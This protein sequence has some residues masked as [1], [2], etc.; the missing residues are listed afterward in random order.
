MFMCFAPSTSKGDVPKNSNKADFIVRLLD[1][2]SRPG[3]AISRALGK[4]AMVEDRVQTESRATERALNKVGL[5]AAA[6]GANATRGA[7]GLNKVSAAM[8]A[9]RRAA[10]VSDAGGRQR[11]RGRFV[12]PRGVERRNIRNA[13]VAGAPVA[14]AA[15]GIAGQVGGFR[16]AIQAVRRWNDATGEA[17]RKQLALKRAFEDTHFGRL[18]GGFKTGGKAVARLSLSLAK[19]AAQAVATAGALFGVGAAALAFKTVQAGAF[20]ERSR[21]ALALL[22]GSADEGNRAFELARNTAKDLGLDVQDVV[23]QF[24]KLRAAQFTIGETENLVKLG[25]DLQAIGASAEQVDRAILAITQVKAKGRLQSEELLQLSE[26]GVSMA[27]VF[28]E[29]EK[30]TGKSTSGVRKLL[31]AGKVSGDQGVLAIQNAILH[32]VGIERAG[33]AGRQFADETLTG[34]VNRLKTLPGRLLLDLG[35]LIDTKQ[36]RKIVNQL[37]GALRNID[38]KTLTRGINAVIKAF[39]RAI[40]F[41]ISFAEGFGSKIPDIVT[42]MEDFGRAVDPTQTRD[43]GR[44]LGE[45][46][47]IA[48]EKGLRLTEKIL[49]LVDAL[50]D[51]AKEAGRLHRLLF[52]DASSRPPPLPTEM[53]AI[54]QGLPAAGAMGGDIAGASMLFTDPERFFSTIFSTPTPTPRPQQP[55]ARTVTVAPS[56]QVNVT[57]GQDAQRTAE[58]VREGARK[59]LED[60]ADGPMREAF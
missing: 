60:F 31:Q 55:Q 14:A 41:G 4:I 47:G 22:T 34:M 40:D 32:K 8:L 49:E 7:A 25:A 51:A 21:K 46:L 17:R 35:E 54:Q 1:R 57:G 18:I 28:R 12:T 53:A 30:Q 56:I 20:G 36:V 52:G 11:V 6:M 48:L 42:A 29:L 19:M 39:G 43:W 15:P 24:I 9:A 45:E 2:L 23:K 16:A 26:A 58:A 33:D 10:V 13:R 3:K 59:A 38:T 44:V 27:L 5:R 37:E 50:R